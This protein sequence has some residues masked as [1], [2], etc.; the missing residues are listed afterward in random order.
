MSAGP[1]HTGRRV[2]AEE[3]ATLGRRKVPTPRLP[4]LYK[5]RAIAQFAGGNCVKGK[6][7]FFFLGKNGKKWKWEGRVLERGGN[8]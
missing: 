2:K 7:V 8:G 6:E 4:L 1:P 3:D 5:K